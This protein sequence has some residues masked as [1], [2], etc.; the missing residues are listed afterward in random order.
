M[1][2]LLNTVTIRGVFP[3]V[4]FCWQRKGRAKQ[5]LPVTPENRKLP[6]PR[7]NALLNHQ[8]ENPYYGFQKWNFQPVSFPSCRSLM[9]TRTWLPPGWG[10][11]WPLLSQTI[12][13]SLETIC[14]TCS[15]A[16]KTERREASS[17]CSRSLRRVVPFWARV[18]TSSAP[19]LFLALPLM[20]LD[21]A[22]VTPLLEILPSALPGL[23]LQSPSPPPPVTSRKQRAHFTPW[24]EAQWVR[25]GHFLAVWWSW[26]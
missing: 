8:L 20:A 3:R 22:A 6:V 7:Y 25:S 16:Y 10:L 13:E 2:F 1:L 26:Q 21:C 11:I 17:D 9:V 18:L 24:Q 15:G 23:P 19:V 12:N 4:M 14:S 5:M